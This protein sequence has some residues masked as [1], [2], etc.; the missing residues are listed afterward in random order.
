[1]AHLRFLLVAARPFTIPYPDHA[2]IYWIAAVV[3][4]YDEFEVL[5]QDT[6]VAAHVITGLPFLQ[7]V[8]RDRS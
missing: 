1:M 2:H 8:G 6:F 5:V 3:V 7:A 4:C